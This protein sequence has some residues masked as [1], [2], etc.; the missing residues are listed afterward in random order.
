MCRYTYVLNE[1]HG[2][3][4]QGRKN[5]HG[6]TK[7]VLGIA[8]F[9]LAHPALEIVDQYFSNPMVPGAIIALNMILPVLAGYFFGPWSGAVAGS[10]G[11][12]VLL[13]RD[14]NIL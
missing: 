4:F 10:A 14:R 6:D 3:I 9:T 5:G 1:P 13:A 2:R 11:S 12:G 7:A 8:A